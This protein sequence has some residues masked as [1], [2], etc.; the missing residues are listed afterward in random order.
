MTAKY[1]K[2]SR[3]FV[4]GHLGLV[5]SSLC[6]TLK[7]RG[8]DRLLTRS[9]DE[10]DLCQAAAVD[11]FFEAEKPEIVILAAAKVGGIKANSDFPADF[12]LQNLLIQTNVINAAFK[13]GVKRL[14]FLGSSCIYPRLCPQPIA[15]SY[16]LSGA[17][18]PTN[19][20]Y[21]IAKIAG[22]KLCEALN[23]QYGT[24]YLSVM[25]T[26][27]YG[28]GDNYNLATSH[29]IPA[30]VRRFDE[31]KRANAPF[32]ELWGSGSARREFLYVDDLADACCHLLLDTDCSELTN[33]GTGEDM[34]IAQLAQVI[35]KVVDYRGEIRFDHIHPDGTPQK[36]LDIS[37]VKAL[38]WEAK[39]SLEDGLRQMYEDYLLTV[40]P[41]Q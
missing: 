2:N 15:E 26:N 14:L 21:A 38:G 12:I 16:L 11:R 28:P 34:T 27:L 35:A 30:L 31:A 4:A 9:R 8:Y 13:S 39:T 36:L 40:L 19:E 29:V 7:A 18:E 20:S 23:R 3:I 24:Q 5:G 41:Q 37:K 33:I 10:L 17:L 1:P 22:L 6:R 25:P 32:I